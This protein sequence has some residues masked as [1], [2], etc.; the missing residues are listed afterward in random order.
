MHYL[1]TSGASMLSRQH[2]LLCTS[3][4][5]VVIGER[6]SWVRSQFFFSHL[7]G[8]LLGDP[9]GP[10]M[11]K[12]THVLAIPVCVCYSFVARSILKNKYDRRQLRY[13]ADSHAMCRAFPPKE[14]THTHTPRSVGIESRTRI[15]GNVD[16]PPYM[17]RTTIEVSVSSVLHQADS[18]W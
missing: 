14:G 18:I 10:S 1:R 3:T 9:K 7:L 2:S 8:S 13:S 6:V 5:T 15:L 16:L 4:T 17:T 11:V 12:V